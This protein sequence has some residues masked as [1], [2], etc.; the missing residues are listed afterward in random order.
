MRLFAVMLYCCISC[1][2]SVGCC[3]TNVDVHTMTIFPSAQS[4]LD[5]ELDP[6]DLWLLGRHED[7]IA[8]HG[9]PAAFAQL[10]A[11]EACLL[12]AAAG[13]AEGLAADMA[14]RCR[15]ALR[16]RWVLISLSIVFTIE[17]QIRAKLRHGSGR[18]RSQF[19]ASMHCDLKSR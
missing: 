18:A 8:Q 6:M 12:S 14:A 10:N 7:L 1:K 4:K 19:S 15:H 16:D 5:S 3:R 13:G 9:S 11:L 2:Q 17:Q